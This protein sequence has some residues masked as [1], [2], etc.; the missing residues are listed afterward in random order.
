MV[1]V[2]AFSRGPGC[3]PQHQKKTTVK[4]TAQQSYLNRQYWPSSKEF[5]H[6]SLALV[7]P[8]QLLMGNKYHVTDCGSVPYLLSKA[9]S[10]Q[11]T[12]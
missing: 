7:S 9:Y 12:E 3:N 8:S 2:C 1:R 11:L 6:T 4:I 10:A 5:F